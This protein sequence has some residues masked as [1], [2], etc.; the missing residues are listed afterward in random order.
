M[1]ADRHATTPVQ[2]FVLP[3]RLDALTADGV[4]ADVE[5]ISNGGIPYLTLDAGAMA[6]LS[7][8]G[9]RV[10]LRMRARF[11]KQGAVLHLAN[12]QA[13][14]HEVLKA[15]GLGADLQDL[16]GDSAGVCL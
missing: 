10:L 13:F 6:Y 2:V 12:L 5:K 1:K 3:E 4:Y 8:K 14:A 16:D 15:S 7:S 9:V 11:Q